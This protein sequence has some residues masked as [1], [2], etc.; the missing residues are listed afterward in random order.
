MTAAAPDAPR[1]CVFGAGAV[2]T[3]VAA[4]LSAAGRPVTVVARGARL[5]ALR[6]DGLVLRDAAGC[7][8]R[9]PAR[10]CAADEAGPQDLLLLAVKAQ[11]IAGTLSAL[12]PLI[13][14]ETR[15]VPLV[16][17]IPWW[18]FQPQRHGIVRAVDPEGRIAAAIDPARIIGAVLFLTSTLQPDGVVDVQGTERLILG[19]IAGPDEA[20]VA[21]VRALFEGCGI[22]VQASGEIRRDLWAKVALNLATNPLSVIAGATLHEQFHDPALLPV[23]RAVLEESIAVARAHGIEPRLALDEMIEVG[24]RAGPFYTSMA[25]DFRRGAPLEMGAIGLSVLELAESAEIAMPTARAMVELCRFR[26]AKR[27][28]G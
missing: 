16:N 13:T 4:R 7:V 24:R 14:P 2:G 1:T 26:A 11:D 18:Y 17:G 19:A 23:V 22:A 25:Q 21:P 28:V 15:I 20:S 5:A 8:S 6:R 27:E 9:V 10:A 12:Q 3:L